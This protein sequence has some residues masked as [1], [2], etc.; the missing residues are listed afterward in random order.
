MALP[1]VTVRIS[2]NVDDLLAKVEA[3]KAA[4]DDLEAKAAES[5]AA[6]KGGGMGPGG[7]GGVGGVGRGGLVDQYGRPMERTAASEAERTVGTV[8]RP[9]ARVGQDTEK[10]TKQLGEM[11]QMLGGQLPTGL[12]NMSS[13]LKSVSAGL[14]SV[15]NGAGQ[16]GKAF[17]SLT[18]I[19]TG[20]LSM[21]GSLAGFAK[22]WAIMVPTLFAAPALLGAIGG[23]AGGLAGSFTVLT[24]AVG[25]FAIGAM[26]AL[27]YVTSVSNL[28][29]YDALSAPLQRL[30]MAYH[31][32]SNEITI[33]SQT[34]GSTTVVSVLI[35]MFN[36]LTSVVQRLGPLMGQSASAVQSAWNVIS[37]GLLSPQFTQFVNWVG[38]EATPVMTTFAQ[39]LVNF[40]SGWTG[41]MED[42][43]PAI[44]LFDNG[45]VHL[46]Q[47]FA[48]W[49][50]S[51]K[52]KAQVEGF[53]NYVKDA[54]PQISHFWGGLGD[55]IEKFFSS[56]AKGAPGMAQDLGNFFTKIA[57]AM[58][59]LVNFGEHVLPGIVKG[60]AAF[61][62][63]FAKGFMAE[64]GPLLDKM[65]GAKGPDWSK[66]GDTVGKLAGDLLKV[67]PPLATILIGLV[68]FGTMLARI[69]GVI[70]GIVA[71]WVVLR[72][73]MAV[74]QIVAGFTMIAS[75]IGT[76]IEALGGAVFAIAAFIGAPVVLVAV[77]IGAVIAGVILLATHWSQVS[78][79][80]INGARFMGGVFHTVASDLVSVFQTMIG[81]IVR[82]F[83]QLP[84]R[85]M[86]AMGSIPKDVGSLL[87]QIP[88]IGGLLSAGG[89]IASLFGGGASTSGASR[90][91]SLQQQQ[92]ASAL[93]RSAQ[94]L[95]AGIS[96][97]G[98]SSSGPINIQSQNT[99]NVA[100][101]VSPEAMQQIDLLL[102]QHDQIMVQ[103]LQQVRGAYG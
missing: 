45:M 75:G 73:V 18:G 71:A 88:G 2:G 1:P 16:F 60:F 87:S 42:L 84:G 65:S 97:K 90:Q 92:S 39:T 70:Q 95:S 58:P 89:D 43:T 12:A 33:F 8:D 66:I 68:S 76:V 3:A 28:A 7:V 13:L 69:P 67:L 20:P 4:I 77:G 63:G 55:I 49:A 48:N 17:G 99:I 86:Q 36:T 46:T 25:L 6:T 81:D 94:M 62:G 57:D 5:Q 52:G 100:G 74:G 72:G 96:S 14:Q 11:R 34:M 35:N 41:L 22:T 29:Q 51:P 38:S 31:N 61:T 32:L 102:R 101:P 9:M 26:K 54:W 21:L 23:A 40:A 98:A 64:I 85:I 27:S 24:S 79:A 53:I 83:E 91:A 15:S 80:V 47:T 103:R 44:T 93:Q 82:F 19:F 10:A 78:T 59:M 50:N 37:Q 56:A 30:Y